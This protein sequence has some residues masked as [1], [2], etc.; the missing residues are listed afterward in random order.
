MNREEDAP[1]A[2]EQ[3]ISQLLRAG[4]G[5][6]SKTWLLTVAYV[7]SAAALV[8][9]CAFFGLRGRP[10]MLE[11]LNT[12]L[13][14]VSWHGFSS[15][16]MALILERIPASLWVNLVVLSGLQLAALTL[17]PLKEMISRR[18]ES[19]AGLVPQNHR[20]FT[21]L[22]QGAEE[23]KLLL[24]NVSV[25]GLILWVAYAPGGLRQELGSLL[26][27]LH[28]AAF[29]AID[30]MAPLAQRH[31]QPVERILGAFLRRPL[32]PLVFGLLLT[33][34]ASFLASAD[35]GFNAQFLALVFLANALPMA[36]G[37]IAGTHLM[38]LELPG[39]AASPAGNPRR[40][41]LA[42]MAVVV[43]V[44]LQVS[45]ASSLLQSIHRKSQVLKCNYSLPLDGFRLNSPNWLQLVGGSL[46]LDGHFS[47]GISNPTAFD[48]AM[49]SNRLV[50]QVDGKTW[51][52]GS[53][54]EAQV[55]AGET[56]RVRVPFEMTLNALQLFEGA[57]QG[58]QGAKA[59]WGRVKGVWE[60]LDSPASVIDESE[61][62]IAEAQLRFE[63]ARQRLGVTLYIEILPGLEFPF[64]LLSPP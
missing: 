16:L 45:V 39:I 53:L 60:R 21:L 4:R 41:M 13:F 57:K 42:W 7:F 43:I 23:L 35:G 15:H 1:G 11:A 18:V 29:F 27:H 14:P 20:E 50:V 46:T 47:V 25:G 9:L 26:S 51:W 22:R 8:G 30:F 28:L 49:E 40:R 54:P 2:F 24:I 64:Y 19:E 37:V 56:N 32:R 3:V 17:F 38:A 31:G 33:A 59:L 36:W 61:R 10:A 63:A 48:L 52:E 62:A 12:Y 5:L 55:G 58:W 6:N 44:S 34:P